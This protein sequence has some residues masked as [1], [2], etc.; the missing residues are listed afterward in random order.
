MKREYT[1]ISSKQF[2]E[3]IKNKS[4]LVHHITNYVTVN[5]CANATLAIGASPIMTAQIEE[6]EDII[7]ISSALVVNIGTM[8]KIEAFLTAPKIAN[9]KNVPVILDPVG[10][11][12]SKKRNEVIE[13]MLINSKFAVIKGN[14]SEILSIAGISANTKGVDVSEEDKNTGIMKTSQI[15]MKLAKTYNSVIIV[16]GKDDIVADENNAYK[17]SN[18][19]AY[20]SKIT[21][22][23]C[24]SA[25]ILGSFIGANEDYLTSSIIAI[26]T[27]GIAGE[28]AY[29]KTKNIG[30]GSFRVSLIDNLSMMNEKIFEK[31]AK[32]EKIF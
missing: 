5:D 16:T 3:N 17:I 12:A 25:S 18:G 8:D 23:G 15:A 14:L 30:S 22:T 13:N 24:M 29:E 1:M 21:G 6:L 26:S 31:Y 32:I 20:M 19:V 27:M 4:P 10:A 2:L 9:A 11:G 7:S 28:L